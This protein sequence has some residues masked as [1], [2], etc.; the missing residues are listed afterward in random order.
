MEQQ[1]IQ[2]SPGDGGF[3]SGFFKGASNG[4]LMMGIVTALGLAAKAAALISFPGW[5]VMDAAWMLIMPTATGLFGGIMAMRRTGE[6]AT[7]A[8]R[9]S[10][11]IVRDAETLAARNRDL[12]QAPDAPDQDITADETPQRRNW[13]DRTARNLQSNMRWQLI[14][15]QGSKAGH[16]TDGHLESLMREREQAELAAQH[17]NTQR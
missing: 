7:A 17:P 6:E 13:T 15:D 16:R 2:H 14:A 3:F 9:V 4:A 1:A 11:D 12:E 10:R 5:F 8:K